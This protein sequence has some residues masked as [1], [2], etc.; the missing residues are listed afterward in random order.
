M[1]STQPSISWLVPTEAK[2]K[3]ALNTSE[4]CLTQKVSHTRLTLVFL[5]KYNQCITYH[6]PICPWSSTGVISCRKSTDGGSSAV[7][8][9]LIAPNFG[10]SDAFPLGLQSSR[11][12]RLP[13]SGLTKNTNW[14]IRAIVARF[15]I[16][17]WNMD[18]LIRSQTFFPSAS[19]QK[20][21]LRVDAAGERDSVSY[22]WWKRSLLRFRLQS[23]LN[24]SMAVHASYV[25][26]SFRE[27]NASVATTERIF[28]PCFV[29]NVRKFPLMKCFF[30]AAWKQRETARC[31][32]VSFVV[33][34]SKIECLLQSVI[35]FSYS[36]WKSS[37]RYHFWR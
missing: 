10:R 30:S 17:I 5:R 15:W 31:S 34:V 4:H 25:Q 3:Y 18:R 11:R 37:T 29:F 1:L 19:Q 2:N 36:N 24:H 22:T 32:S 12:C 33:R 16:T 9:F 27:K 8:Y 7:A 28:Q 21:R 20:W 14:P 35:Q 6:E 26:R 13:V 23:L